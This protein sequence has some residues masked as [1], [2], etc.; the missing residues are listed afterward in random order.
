MELKTTMN[1]F[2]KEFKARLEGDNAEA[3]AQKALRSS[4][5]A[6]DT[7]IACKVGDLV[8]LED[9]VETCQD[10]LV[11]A[12]VNNGQPIKDRDIY[13]KNLISAQN[14]LIDAEEALSEHKRLLEFLKEQK[15]LNNKEINS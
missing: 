5:S 1:S 12:R 3:L 6:L 7:H 10:D 11:K 8:S 13:V 4:N 15:E 2:I 9:R 14:N